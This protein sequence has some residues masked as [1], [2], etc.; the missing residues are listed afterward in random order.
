MPIAFF[1]PYSFA[2]G[3]ITVPISA[4]DDVFDVM[5]LRFG[6]KYGG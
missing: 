2:F 4:R 6:S 3:R 5:E 1:L